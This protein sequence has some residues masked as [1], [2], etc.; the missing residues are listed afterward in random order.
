M[1]KKNSVLKFI[2]IGLLVGLVLIIVGRCQ[3][4]ESMTLGFDSPGMSSNTYTASGETTTLVV[5]AGL[6]MTALAIWV[7]S[8]IISGTLY[9]RKTAMVVPLVLIGIASI[10]S[11]AAAS[12]KH[13]AM[14]GSLS[15]LSF[16]VVGILMVQLLDRSWKVKFL[17][18][19]I[20]ATAVTSTYTCWEQYSYEI[21][22]VQ[23]DYEKSPEKFIEMTKIQ[24]P[25]QAWQYV[26]RIKSGDVHGFFTVSNTTASFF[27]LAIAAGAALLACRWSNVNK[28]KLPGF[29]LAGLV[30][31][32]PLFGMALTKS[33]GGIA[34][35]LVGVVLVGLLLLGRKIF[36]KHW[37]KSLIAF[38]LIVIFGI[39]SVIHYGNQNGRLP[40][41]SML[42][43]WQYWTGAT[44]IFKDN[45]LSGTGANN[46][47][48]HYT[49]YK[50]AS[51][52]EVVQ[53]PHCVGLS[54]GCQWGIIG[55]I[56]FVWLIIAMAIKISR[57]TIKEICQDNENIPQGA[58]FALG[59][60]LAIGAMIIRIVNS[61]LGN[62]NPAELS[63]YYLIKM[64]IPAAIW[65]GSFILFYLGCNTNDTNKFNPAVMILSSG[66]VAFLIHNSIDMAFFVPGVG[67]CAFALLAAMLCMKSE[68]Y[69]KIVFNRNR[70]ILLSFI[71]GA[72]AIVM[73]V[74]FIGPVCLSQ[75]KMNEMRTAQSYDDAMAMLQGANDIWSYDPMA[76]YYASQLQ[77]N[78]WM[79]TGQID[80]ME[81]SW[82]SAQRAID[83]DKL[84][85]KFYQ[86]QLNL[87]TI[88]LSKKE[89]KDRHE[90]FYQRAKKLLEILIGQ[91][92]TNSTTLIE[93]AKLLLN[94]NDSLEFRDK[95]N[96]KI[97]MDAIEKALQYENEFLDLQQQMYP[98][99]T[100]KDGLIQ[101]KELVP[102]FTKLVNRLDYRDIQWAM[103]KRV[104][105]E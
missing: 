80:Y 36:I 51:A 70:K 59:I 57:P 84:K 54:I 22:V 20:V 93:Y 42:L 26:G 105:I 11:T 60:I 63:S 24:T 28:E 8:R 52:P 18:A 10:I 19:G 83:C 38:S 29:I 88:G 30:A 64:I 33:K 49:M 21:P 1:L 90:D 73:W 91:Y 79:E 13:E 102:D 65:L 27:I 44:E 72:T 94:H 82:Q 48:R 3:I 96:E 66:L 100:R 6:T 95:E 74:M 34:A 41:N 32:V 45:W 92:P 9:W 97:A 56:G 47:G 99:R 76:N 69:T 7:I 89:F 37:K 101:H 17:L 104:T 12:N 71:A 67:Y 81:K 61:S 77:M 4:S 53:D 55:L 98:E 16:L 39:G 86:Q 35:W 14:V 15:L 43:R 25:F 103:D 50:T 62:L 58:V 75:N 87:M 23:S 46:F 78:R 2:D 31:A 5:M 40:G 68:S 85:S